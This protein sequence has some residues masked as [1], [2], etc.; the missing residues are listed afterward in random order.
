MSDVPLFNPG[1]FDPSALLP[2]LPPDQLPPALPGLDLAGMGAL[3]AG[4]FPNPVQLPDGPPRD[5]RDILLRQLQQIATDMPPDSPA[6]PR[7]RQLSPVFTLALSSVPIEDLTAMWTTLRSHISDV[8]RALAE[9]AA[10]DA[11]V[12]AGASG[13]GT[14]Q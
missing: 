1:S 5:L 9:L 13:A 11:S 2:Q 3:L 8:D 4:A 7:W 10:R 12:D 14:A 6:A